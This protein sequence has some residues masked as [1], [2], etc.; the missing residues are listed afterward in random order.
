MAK[1]CQFVGNVQPEVIFCTQP[2]LTKRQ[3]ASSS[4][5]PTTVQCRWAL[6]SWRKNV[7]CLTVGKRCC[8]HSMRLHHQLH[9]SMIQAASKILPRCQVVM[10]RLRPQNLI[11]IRKGTASFLA[12]CPRHVDRKRLHLRQSRL[13]WHSAKI[14]PPWPTHMHS[15]LPFCFLDGSA[16][17]LQMLAVSLRSTG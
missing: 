13:T 16:G 7:H 1:C 11:L 12:H 14:P 9:R 3:N 10:Q 6:Q 15:Q 2:H 5:G 4:Q 17:G 8:K